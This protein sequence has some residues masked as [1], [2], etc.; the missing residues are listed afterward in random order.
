[1]NQWRDE[2]TKIDI[3]NS[4]LFH[5]YPPTLFTHPPRTIQVSAARLYEKRRVLFMT[6]ASVIYISA[7]SALTYGF[8][9]DQ[10]GYRVGRFIFTNVLLIPS[11]LFCIARWYILAMKELR[12]PTGVA[13]RHFSMS[14]SR[15]VLGRGEGEMPQRGEKEKEEE[16]EQQQ[17]QQAK[18]E[19]SSF[20]PK[21]SSPPRPLQTGVVTSGAS[22]AIG[23]VSSTSTR[24]ID[25]TPLHPA[26]NQQLLSRL[27][28]ILYVIVCVWLI[29]ILTDYAI[30]LRRVL[31]LPPAPVLL[32]IRTTV[33]CGLG[34]IDSL[35]LGLDGDCCSCWGR[36]KEKWGGEE[37]GDVEAGLTSRLARPMVQRLNSYSHSLSSFKEKSPS[38]TST[39]EE[40]ALALVA[41][42]EAAHQAKSRSRRL[43][44][45]RLF[46]STYNM[47]GVL[48]DDEASVTAFVHA[49][50]HWIPPNLDVYA[51]GVQECSCLGR[52]RD[53]LHTHLGGPKAYTLYT[54]EIGDAVVLHGYVGLTLFVRTADVVSGA[55]YPHLASVNRLA[56]GVDVMGLRIPNKGVVGLSARYHDTTLAFVTAHF[57]S[58]KKG[59]NKLWRRNRDA[60]TM[61]RRLCLVWD[62]GAAFDVNH[63]HMH[64]FFCGDANYRCLTS[65]RDVLSR[66][67]QS[68]R[69]SQEACLAGQRWR[70]QQYRQL[71]AG[72]TTNDEQEGEEEEKEEELYPPYKPA[73][74]PLSTLAVS[75]FGSQHL[76]VTKPT[77]GFLRRFL[78]SLRPEQ[79]SSARWGR[80]NS[81]S[82]SVS[83]ATTERGEATL[84]YLSNYSEEEGEDGGALPLA[85]AL[86]SPSTSSSSGPWAWVSSLDE[87][88]LCKQQ[89]L[90]FW[91]WREGR[92]RFPPSY[93]WQRSQKT[94]EGG[95][96]KGEG[97]AGDFTSLDRL[98]AAYTTRTTAT[99]PAVVPSVK[100]EED[101]EEGGKN[102]DEENDPL[103]KGKDAEE[104]EDEDASTVRTPSYTDRV[105]THSL[106]GHGQALRWE[107]YDMADGLEL[108]DHRPVA[109]T[110]TLQVDAGARKWAVEE[111]GE[112]E[113]AQLAVFTFTFSKPQLELFSPQALTETHDETGG[114]GGRGE[115]T[116]SSTA[117]DPHTVTFLFPLVPE[118]PVAEERLA[119]ALGDA[120]PSTRRSSNSALGRGGGGGEG[121]G[122]GPTTT[123]SQR[124]VRWARGFPVR[125][126]VAASPRFSQHMLLK[127]VDVQGRDLG[128]TVVPVVVGLGAGWVNKER[129]LRLPLTRGGAFQGW[130]V[131]DMSVGLRKL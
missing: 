79:P 109:A 53:L 69:L 23:S 101:E 36:S 10:R 100:E 82:N 127:L 59:R 77:G 5:F 99:L 121:G 51:I 120:L 43:K 108:S 50:P 129:K 107:A 92:I 66:V 95:G 3:K 32:L 88:L 33:L 117:A 49:L 27:T 126:E 18:G 98:F 44:D 21:T 55:F 1:M 71:L 87:L 84:S 124:D 39:P 125:F 8:T 61:L 76:S 20:R 131:V 58:D 81:T 105:L 25:N 29:V 62:D 86:P 48:L 114:G 103:E 31:H 72:E 11:T 54:N 123:S 102:G 64:T 75:V 78:V 16:E 13:G 57:A 9:R 112:E 19:G 26:V 74:V 116:K 73:V 40:E 128:E 106:P 110:Y 119:T 24:G 17:Q 6:V 130:V 7:L 37:R 91:G 35:I 28:Y 42:A 47:G 93:R 12:K 83:S 46:V 56:T 45:L 80:S 89:R 38:C 52:F 97:L 34:M 30:I 96:G 70:Q 94:A 113:E 63:Q 4:W 115:A 67:A 15:T 65:P 111:E 68:A 60:M 118:D 2:A 104:D 90:V 41:T 122:G 22:S 85:L 14:G